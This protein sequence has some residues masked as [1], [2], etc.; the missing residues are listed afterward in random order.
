V[1]SKEAKQSLMPLRKEE[2]NF[3]L[4][5]SNRDRQVFYIHIFDVIDIIFLDDIARFKNRPL[6]LY[7]TP[8]ISFLENFLG[9]IK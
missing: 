5:L 6:W 9:K 1:Y 4:Y 7:V 8:N 2:Q 3:F